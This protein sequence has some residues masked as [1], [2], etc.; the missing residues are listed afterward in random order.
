VQLAVPPPCAFTLPFNASAAESQGVEFGLNALLTDSLQL[1]VSASV[2]EAEL[3]EDAPSI[4]D[5]G[6]RLPGTPE[7]NATVALD[8]A[9]LLARKEAWARA[10][11]AWVSDFHNNFQGAPPELGDYTTINVSAGV[12][13]GGWNLEFYVINLTDSDAATWANPIWT[14]YDRQSRL[15]PRTIGARVEIGFGND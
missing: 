2:V 1:D 7:Y 3:T 6:D 12:E 8:Y 11:I 4:G 14:P 15:R 9:F 5:S 10:D 13:I